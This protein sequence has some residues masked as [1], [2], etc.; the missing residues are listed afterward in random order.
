MIQDE[1]LETHSNSRIEAIKVVGAADHQDTV[2][3]L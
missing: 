1:R 2:V 3:T